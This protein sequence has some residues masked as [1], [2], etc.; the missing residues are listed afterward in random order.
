MAKYIIYACPAGRLAEQLDTY[1]TRTR[2]E[3]GPNAAHNYMPH[4]TL[5]G[6]FHDEPKALPLYIAALSQAL[7]QHAP[8]PKPPLR[9]L[10]TEFHPQFHG[11]LLEAP[12][13]Q[14]V[15]AEFVR[16]AASPSRSE[17]LR[18]KDWLHLSLAY[19]FLPEKH[20]ALAALAQE[21]VDPFASVVWELRF[22]EL[23][24][25]SGWSC[26]AAWEL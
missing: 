5:T 23:H 19:E 3:H 12:W 7:A 24:P 10:G 16:L 26:H 6:F 18:V 14:Q 15:I 11:L 8:T 4:C 22:Y 2:V 17:A 13:L 25:E 1:F 9:V 20:A 21:I